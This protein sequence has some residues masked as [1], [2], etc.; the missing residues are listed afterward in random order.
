MRHL[1]AGRKLGR[2]SSHRRALYSN[3]VAALITHGKIET[4]EAKAKELRSIADRTIHWGV[5]VADIV[6]KGRPKGASKS[7]GE[8]Q[9]A[10]LARVVHARRMA[11]RGLK[12]DGE[13][14]RAH[15]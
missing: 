4:T 13:L 14:G 2:T 8:G 9:K 15:V 5:A 12:D 6:R 1:K 11:R 10:E 7:L 3:L